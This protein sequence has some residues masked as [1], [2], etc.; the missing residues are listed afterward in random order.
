MNKKI[1]LVFAVLIILIGAVILLKSQFVK[2]D[3]PTATE[4][5]QPEFLPFGGDKIDI[6]KMEK[7]EA[8]RFEDTEQIEKTKRG[9]TYIISIQKGAVLSP[10]GNMIAKYVVRDVLELFDLN[11]YIYDK[12]G[13]EFFKRNFGN[14][15]TEEQE[16]EFIDNEKYLKIYYGNPF[17]DLTSLHL[18][19]IKNPDK[20]IIE[21]GVT[22]QYT[23]ISPK[24]N[25]IIYR[26]SD[27]VRDPE[28]NE[29]VE[30]KE[31]TI[32]RNF[33]KGYVK[34]LEDEISSTLS[35]ADNN[36]FACIIRAKELIVMFDDNCNILWEHKIDLKRIVRNN[37][38]IS[39][40]NKTFTYQYRFPEQQ[41]IIDNST[42]KIIKTIDLKEGEG[43]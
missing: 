24:K 41:F 13:K 23:H 38:K 39:S 31:K 12:N 26:K 6:S 22:P 5:P 25:M 9:D 32:V 29:I 27:T 16:I 8:I 19:N 7:N 35:F 28:T 11:L 2:S 42:G 33:E 18:I 3:K 43:L 4:Q 10:S 1:V 40:D 21:N 37:F 30:S 36:Y 14:V 34:E 20:D 17:N 15:L